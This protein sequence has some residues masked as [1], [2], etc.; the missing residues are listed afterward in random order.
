MTRRKVSREF[1]I[2][3]VRLVRDRCVAVAQA[4][5]DLDLAQSVLRRWKRN[6][7]IQRWQSDADT[8][9]VL[10]GYAA[11]EQDHGNRRA[12]QLCPC[13]RCRRPAPSA[14][15]QQVRPLEQELGV[16][17][18]AHGPC[19]PAARL[20]DH[21]LHTL[22]QRRPAGQPDRYRV[23]AHGHHRGRHSPDRQHR[24]DRHLRRT[25]A[26]RFSRAPCGAEPVARSGADTSAVRRAADGHG[27]TD[28]LAP[29]GH[30]RAAA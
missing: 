9:M 25:G 2:E 16:R 1:R 15:S 28:P 12:W 4:A 18:A 22:S 7:V 27:G 20:E 30:H 8:L 21:G 24:I 29:R 6:L 10:R 14:V 5:H 23:V 13:G 3:A 19:G 11:V 17:I 26:G